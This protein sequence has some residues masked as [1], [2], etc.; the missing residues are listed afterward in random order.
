MYL[1]TYIRTT[2][3]TWPLASRHGDLPTT[4]LRLRPARLNAS[5]YD[6]ASRPFG[7]RGRTASQV[8]AG[9]A[10]AR[11]ARPACPRPRARLT[12][13]RSAAAFDGTDS[14]LAELAA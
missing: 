12:L 1:R 8:L 11:A 13:C 9:G 6:T 3:C 10:F 5:R 14:T 7:N 4:R 2:C